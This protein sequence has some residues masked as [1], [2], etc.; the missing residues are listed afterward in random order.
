MSQRRR[1]QENANEDV[2]LEEGNTVHENNGPRMSWVRVGFSFFMSNSM[3]VLTLLSNCH[4]ICYA[5]SDNT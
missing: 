1:T 2:D 4:L 3:Y 5:D